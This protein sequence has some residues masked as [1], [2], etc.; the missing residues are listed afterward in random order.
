M[1]W[2]AELAAGHSAE[3]AE[4]G[5]SAEWAG[6]GMKL[7]YSQRRKALEIDDIDLRS[8]AYVEH[9]LRVGDEVLEVAVR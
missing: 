5:G 9:G 8:Q 3:T 4:A 7:Y 6:F 2:L 1:L